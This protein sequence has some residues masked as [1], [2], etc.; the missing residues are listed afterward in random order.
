MIK[1]LLLLA[2]MSLA[3]AAAVSADWPIPPCAPGCAVNV[4]TSVR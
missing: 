3:F 4:P 1:K 2:G